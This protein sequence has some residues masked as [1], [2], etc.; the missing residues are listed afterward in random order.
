MSQP[1]L[2][3]SSDQYLWLLGLVDN[4][5]AAYVTGA[6]V[7]AVIT[8]STGTTVATVSLTYQSGS[9]TVNGV[10]S[11][12][13]NYRGLLSHS[14]SLTAGQN[15]TVTVTVTNGSAQLVKQFPLAAQYDAIT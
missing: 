8:D 3:V 1:V 4:S 11:A 7:S 12:G 9:Q 14:T 15:Y 6:T 10:V 2:Y 13:G 5:T